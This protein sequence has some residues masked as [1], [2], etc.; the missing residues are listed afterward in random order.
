MYVN[1]QIRFLLCIFVTFALLLIVPT[2]SA[3]ESTKTPIHVVFEIH[4]HEDRIIQSAGGSKY[5]EDRR[6]EFLLNLEHLDL[7][8]NTV[9]R[10]DAKLTF[11][12]VGP[13]AEL[14]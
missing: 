5:F 4:S 7:L 1:L 3:E 9:D 6:D 11:L 10:Y 2:A 14:C 8:L 13:R 12:S